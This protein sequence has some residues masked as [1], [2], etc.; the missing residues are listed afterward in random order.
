MSGEVQLGGLPPVEVDADAGT[1][2]DHLKMAAMLY[3]EANNGEWAISSDLIY[4]KL[5]QGV[6]PRRVVKS[7]E[8]DMEETAWELAGLK[9][10]TPWLE[11]GAG[12]RLMVIGAGLDL[13][14]ETILGS[15]NPNGSENRTWVDPI[16]VLR[17]EHVFNEKWIAQIRG[18]VGGFGVGSKFAWQIQA[19]GG[20]RFSELFQVTAGYRCISIDYDKDNFVYDVDT[21]GPVLRLGLNF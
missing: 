6:K 17:S 4:M 3:L 14:T 16:I 15:N 11:A 20:Y 12:A 7:G 9:R 19:Y 18:D 5:G 21:Y 2:F 1:I 10:L 8:I 13:E